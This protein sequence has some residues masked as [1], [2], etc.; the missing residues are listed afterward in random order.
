MT[1]RKGV[2]GS[3]P[4]GSSHQRVCTFNFILILHVRKVEALTV[5][6]EVEPKLGL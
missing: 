1:Q 3:V 5:A 6:Q 4:E 2:Q